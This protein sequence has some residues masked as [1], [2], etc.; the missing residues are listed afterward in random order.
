MRKSI[1]TFISALTLSAVIVPAA[2]YADNVMCRNNL[3]KQDTITNCKI[4]CAVASVVNMF[5][6]C[7]ESCVYNTS[8]CPRDPKFG[9]W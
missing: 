7:M 1:V 3:T 8:G 4:G 9:E 6:S 5:N 2:A